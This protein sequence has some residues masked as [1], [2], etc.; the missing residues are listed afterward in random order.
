MHTSTAIK[1]GYDRITSILGHFSGYDNVPSFILEQAKQRG[2]AVHKMYEEMSTGKKASEF[3]PAYKGYY[4]SLCRWMEGKNFLFPIDRLY[5][6]ELMI[7]GMIDG[8]YEDANGLI[9][10]DL[11]TSA[12]IGRTWTQ[13]MGGYLKL[14]SSISIN[15]DRVEIIQINRKG[16]DAIITTI[17]CDKTNEPMFNLDCMNS[18]LE[19]WRIFDK[20]FRHKEEIDLEKL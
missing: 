10:F 15:I 6:D 8:I 9:L 16:E 5:N 13:Q 2:T 3:N 14:L 11:K 7:T 18:F 1:P 19:C 12:S 4:D 20:F 17:C